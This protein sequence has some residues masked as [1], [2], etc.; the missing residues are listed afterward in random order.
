LDSEDDD[1]GKPDPPYEPAKLPPQYSY[2]ELEESTGN[3][4]RRLGYGWSS[5]YAG[6]GKTAIKVLDND[7]E[8]KAFLAAVATMASLSHPNLVPLLGF[9]S[10][11]SHKMLV[12][13]LVDEGQSL[14]CYLFR[15]DSSLLMHVQQRRMIALET[16]R[17]LAYLHESQIIHGGVK[18]ENI[19]I[20]S[21]ENIR[22]VDYGLVSL[23]S[24]SHKLITATDRGS[25]AYMAPE[26]S[27]SVPVTAKVD[28]Y[29]FGVVLLE[30]VSGRS[31]WTQSGVSEEKR[32]LPSWAFAVLGSVPDRLLEIAD[33]RLDAQAL[34]EVDKQVLRGMIFVALWCVQED[35]SNRYPM[36]DV[37][38]MLNGDVT[39][40]RPPPS[41]GLDALATELYAIHG[42]NE[43][44]TDSHR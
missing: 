7:I 13:E 38:G 9:C 37:V 16:A 14:N 17:G 15:K 10:E 32:F 28:V 35:P 41:P 12:Y 19:M 30:L 24:T 6:Q 27:R 25:R 36:S 42:N 4:N 29:S 11:G 43:P 33:P 22:L 44:R 20:D 2:K 26:W 21:D 23:T 3:F 1:T 40:D 5:V 34:S 8:E 39:V 31:C 18:P